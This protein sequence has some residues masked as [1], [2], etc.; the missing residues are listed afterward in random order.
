MPAM[1]GN[2]T[3]RRTMRPFLCGGQKEG[4]NAE[5]FAFTLILVQPSFYFKKENVI[6]FIFNYYFL[7]NYAWQM[8]KYV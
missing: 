7:N 2:N 6:A 1:G 5:W 4:S 3:S 8:Y